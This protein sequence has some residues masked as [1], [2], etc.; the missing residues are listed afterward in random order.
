MDLVDAVNP[1]RIGAEWDGAIV[2]AGTVLADPAAFWFDVEAGNAPPGAV[3]AA[4]RARY[5]TGRPSAVY[6]NRD[7]WAPLNAALVAAGV[8]WCHAEAWPLPGVYLWAAWPG[9]TLAEVF[10]ALHVAPVA[11]Q[12]RPGPDVDLSTPAPTFP[13]R[14]AGYVDGPVSQWPGAAWARFKPLVLDPPPPPKPPPPTPPGGI[15]V[16]AD[17]LRQGLAAFFAPPEPGHPGGEGY[18]RLIQACNES[19]KESLAEIRAAD[20]PVPAA[21]D[22]APADAAPAPTET[23]AAEGEG[24]GP[25]VGEAVAKVPDVPP[26]NA[27]GAWDD[28]RKW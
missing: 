12:D 18:G 3:A 13:A 20:P 6:V 22:T 2:M 24:G 10:A 5:T 15:D 19:I 28:G 17:E 26:N 23:P 9:G 1:E 16:T 27:P 7:T 25:A 14:V 21:A 8:P 4:V 11:V